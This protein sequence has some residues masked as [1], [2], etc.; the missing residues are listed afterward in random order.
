M[1][2]IAT[3][4]I[5]IAL[6]LVLNGVF[7][8][9]ELALMTAKRSRLEHRAEDGDLGA[10]AALDLAA[11]PTAFL[12]TVQVGITLV[13]VLAGAFGGA[14]IS[15]V[16]A[17]QFRTVAWLA[18]YAASL[19]FT[20]VVVVI[21][22][23]SLIIGELVPKRIALANPERMAALVARPMRGISRVGGPLVR[24][25]T[26]ST[27]F[28]L[29]I[30]GLGAVTEPGVTE[31]DIRAL[32]EQ[33]AETGVVHE[34]EREIVE[35][36]FRLGDRAVD[37]LMTPRPDIRWVNVADDADEV[38]QQFIDAASDRMLLCDGDLDTVV[39]LVHAED[40]LVRCVDGAHV[41]DVAVLRAAARPPQF[42]PTTMSGFRLLDSF[43]R[44]RQHA[45]VVLDEYGAV[46]GLVTMDDVVESLIGE[47]AEE[48]AEDL[49]SFTRL[50][51]GSWC[52]DA[53]TPLDEVEGRL[54]LEATNRERADVVTLGGFVMSRLGEVPRE[55]DRFDWS[56]HEVR[57]AKMTG[58]R[59][60]LIT[61]SGVGRPA[62]PS[63]TE[64]LP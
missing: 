47:M 5:I 54:D 4:V 6:L 61:I 19:A 10:R 41:T 29:R 64:P 14:G 2:A 60:S 37:A 56:G 22:Y 18:P 23:L 55:G 39:G 45:A 44:S 58:R 3:E 35:N 11:H 21:T 46:A 59:V 24:A 9:S 7:S 17:E 28:V 40:L 25:L 1:G 42:V 31:Q 15:A 43:R 26:A 34:T 27:N 50:A 13:G 20:L 36:A 63:R 52:I 51:D 30:F 53:G 62:E 12:S 57:V 16:L 48:G 38:R 49:P 33:G 8:M 32:V